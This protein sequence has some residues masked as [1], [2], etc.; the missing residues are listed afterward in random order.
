MSAHGCLTSHW[1][2]D[3]PF[4]L[5]WT[6]SMP[7]FLAPS[8]MI[9]TACRPWIPS[10]RVAQKYNVCIYIYTLLI[11]NH[12]LICVVNTSSIDCSK[13][14]GFWGAEQRFVRWKGRLETLH[15]YKEIRK[16]NT[17]PLSWV[18]TIFDIIYIYKPILTKTQTAYQMP[19][20]A[21]QRAGDRMQHVKARNILLRR[22][23]RS[24]CV[25]L[26]PARLAACAI[27]RNDGRT[28]SMHTQL[29][30]QQL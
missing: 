19:H 29:P 9:C 22:P 7:C 20:I 8:I 6:R 5:Y 24:K 25:M 23:R 11:P 13:G 27:F 15:N 21:T 10:S 26:L 4:Q 3:L 28:L 2:C 16:L 17:C 1:E 12:E 14:S 18:M 30:K